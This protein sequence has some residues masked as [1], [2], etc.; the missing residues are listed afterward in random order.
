LKRKGLKIITNNLHAAV[1]LHLQADFAVSLVG[2][3]I[4]P[5]N[6]GIV[7]AEA[8]E[9]IEQYRV[10]YAVISIGAIEADGTLLDFYSD[11]VSTAQAMMRNARQV[12]LAADHT[13]FNRTAVVRQGDISEVSALFTDEAPPES[14][15]SILIDNDIELRVCGGK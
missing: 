7:G 12:L 8:I 13:K 15:K 4:R 5:H 1:A 10:D 3:T 14:I 11:E 6:G 2:G 9:M